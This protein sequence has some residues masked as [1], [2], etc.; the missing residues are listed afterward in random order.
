MVIKNYIIFQRKLMF[1]GKVKSL[2]QQSKTQRL[3]PR[4][5]RN[6][7]ELYKNL[8]PEKKIK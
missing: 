5:R 3:N 7:L 6:K 4:R 8:V 2:R 1:G